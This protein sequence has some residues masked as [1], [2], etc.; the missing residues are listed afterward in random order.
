MRLNERTL[1]DDLGSGRNLFVGSSCDMFAEDI[2]G[3]WIKRVL[4]HCRKFNNNYLFQSKNPRRFQEFM[5]YF[6]PEIILGTTIESNRFYGYSKAPPPYDRK[7]CMAKLNTN[8]MVS[9]EPIMDFD[10]ESI[11]DMIKEIQPEYVSIG[12]NTNDKV[13]LPEPSWDKVQELIK[14]LKKFTIVKLKDNLNRITQ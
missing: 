12:A 7:E 8:K 3:D 13:K 5:D 6:P 2:S 11:V 4:L 1:K 14:E 9:L 10:L